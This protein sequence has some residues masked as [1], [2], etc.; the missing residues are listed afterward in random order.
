MEYRYIYRI[1]DI[2]VLIKSQ[3]PMSIDRGMQ[4]FLEQ[5]GKESAA[6]VYKVQQGEVHRPVGA[7]PVWIQKNVEVYRSKTGTTQ[8]FRMMRGKRECLA[9]LDK[10]SSQGQYV[11]QADEGFCEMFRM[12]GKVYFYL[13][14]EHVL[15]EYKAFYLHASLV[16]WEESAILFTAPSGMGKST[17]AQLWEKYRGAEILNGDRAIVR[18]GEEWYQA[19]GS[20]YAGSSSLY[21]NASARIRGIVVLGQSKVNRIKR[22]NPGAAM[23]YLL[24]QSMVC[25]WDDDFMKRLLSILADIAEQVPVYH[26]WCRPDESAIEVLEKILFHGKMI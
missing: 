4:P 25:A 20:P 7:V 3:F 22:L 19:Y 21:K 23:K 17:Q 24:S 8:I 14:M 18:K 16:R 13:G 11:L 12:E 5:E 2:K 6:L 9:A 1:A 15:A 26:F 10:E